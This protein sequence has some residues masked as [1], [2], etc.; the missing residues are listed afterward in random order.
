VLRYL[1][2]RKKVI[3]E[4]VDTERTYVGVLM[5]IST[6]FLNPLKESLKTAKPILKQEAIDAIFSTHF[7]E[8]L[9]LHCTFLLALEKRLNEKAEEEQEVSIGAMFLALVRDGANVIHE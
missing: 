2:H 4:I 8:L 5:T 6:V 3:S 9:N 1:E 7:T